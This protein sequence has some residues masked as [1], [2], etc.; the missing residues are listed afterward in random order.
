MRRTRIR[1]REFLRT[2]AAAAAAVPLGTTARGGGALFGAVVPAAAPAYDAKG[3]PTAVLGKT[4]IAVPRIGIGLGSRFCAVKNE[5]TAQEILHAALDHGF[6][7]WDTAYNYTNKSIVSEER[8]GRVLETRRNEVFLATKFEARD[9]DGV[10]R[11][12]EESLKRL[13][14][15][16]LDL[17]QVHLIESMADLDALGLPG[18]ALEALREIKEQK[19]ARFVGLTGHVDAA[20]MAEA[21]RRHDFDTML[22]ALNHYSE[23][24]GDFE[25]GAI[26]AAAARKMGVM[27]I[28]AVR[29]R[30]TVAGLDPLGPHPLRPD[31]AARPRRRRR[32]RQRRGRAQERRPAPGLR[33]PHPGRDEQ[34]RGQARALLCRRRPALDASGL[35]GRGGLLRRRF[36]AGRA[37]PG[38][39]RCPRSRAVR[40]RPACRSLRPRISR[41]G[42]ADGWAPNDPARWRVVEDGRLHDL[43]AHRARR[44]GAGPGARPPS[45]SGPGTTSR[46]S[47]SPAGCAA[48]PSPPLRS[49]TCASSSITATRRISITSTS[50]VRAT[51]STTSSASSTGPTGSRSTPNP[52]AHPFSA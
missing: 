23:R 40:P 10:M 39:R 24:R 18:G 45:P 9:R 30:E 31:P 19:I 33:A 37:G 6:Y 5:D 50:R 38:G 35:P 43:R 1:R 12:L 32:H 42:Q 16:R 3:L 2:M 52:P 17:Y 41:S 14:T 48:T 13:R 34:A 49:G 15:D 26:P 46:P 21:A 27:I 7:Y 44:A 8:L 28:K 51:P 4:G 20:A 47:N 29:P 22:I 11:Q 36:P 25:N